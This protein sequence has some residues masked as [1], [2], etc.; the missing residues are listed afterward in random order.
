[1][2]PET[3]LMGQDPA[4]AVDAGSVQ[5]R[6]LDHEGFRRAYESAA[7]ALRSYVRRATGSG[8]L[9]DDI[10]QEAFLRILRRSLPPLSDRELKSY[11][12]KAA[13]SL[14]HDHWRKISREQRWR[15]LMPFG[16]PASRQTA[17]ESGIDGLFRTLKPRERALLW[18][19]Y[20]EGYSHEEIA[21]VLGVAEK[22]VRVLLFRA[23]RK[24]AKLLQAKNSGREVK[25]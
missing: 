16:R 6:R 17:A 14:M 2:N 7:P 11:L 21:G 8:D 10:V 23:R 3:Y 5:R 22:S 1:M 12:F 25:R 9:A 18:L 20:L 19:A 15:T 24:L 4:S 13:T